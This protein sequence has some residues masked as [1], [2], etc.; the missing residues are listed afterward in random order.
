MNGL[1]KTLVLASALCLFSGMATAK[2]INIDCTTTKCVHYED[3]GKSQ[4]DKFFGTCNGNAPSGMSMVCHAVTGMT[5]IGSTWV[6]MKGQ[7]VPYWSCTCTNWATK[8]KTT[9]VDMTCPAPS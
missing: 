6:Q 7:K 1:A 8:K 4:T 2:Q 9:S 3:M 5:C